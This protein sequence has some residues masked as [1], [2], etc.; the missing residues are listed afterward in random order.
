MNF[1]FTR[2]TTLAGAALAALL[3]P[4]AY[5]ANGF[6]SADT[7]FSSQDASRP[8]G[9]DARILV[10]A[11]RSGLVQFDLSSLPPTSSPAIS[12]RQPSYSSSTASPFR[13]ICRSRP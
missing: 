5:A 11:G 2:K 3:V 10:G 1:N 13:A 12:P 7:Y 6:T 8:F 4:S 9:A